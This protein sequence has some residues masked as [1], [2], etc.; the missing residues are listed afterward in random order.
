MAPS[1][2]FKLSGQA[3]EW[4]GT[5]PDVTLARTVLNWIRGPLV[6]EDVDSQPVE[7]EDGRQAYMSHVPDTY[8]EVV[9]NMLASGQ[10]YVVKIGDLDLD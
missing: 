7:D 3:S 1:Q 9:W 6:Y 4:L 2:D 10:V 8:V 5:N